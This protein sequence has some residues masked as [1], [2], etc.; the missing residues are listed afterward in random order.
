MTTRRASSSLTIALL[1]LLS[2]CGSEDNGMGANPALMGG[3]SGGGIGGTAAVTG[4]VGGTSVTTGG[5]GA[6]GAAGA[7]SG[8][9]GGVA[10]M[11]VTTTGG[12]DAMGGMG[13]SG[14]MD[15]T[16]GMSASGGMG[17]AAPVDGV[18]TLYWLNI[19]SNRVMRSVDFGPEEVIVTR[20]GTAPDGVAVD[21]AGGKVYWSNMGSLLGSGGGTMQRANLDGSDVE[22]II[23]AGIARTP[24]Q[25]Q[26]DLVNRH[27]YFCDRE[28]AK[29]WRAGMDGSNPEAI[30]TDKGYEELVGIALDVA[31]G[32]F[33]FG[34]RIGQK[35]MRANIE[36]P[37]G[38][39][40]ATRTDIEEMFVLSGSMPIDL[41]IDHTNKMIYWTDRQLGTVHRG[42]LEIPAGKTAE[43]RT[44]AE[45]LVTGLVE[46]IGLSLDVPNN[47]MYF[48]ELGGGIWES[49]LDGSGKKRLFSSGSATGI[50]IAHIPK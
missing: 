46:T 4:G 25:M 29:V 31:A 28:G 49:A 15:A 38:A 17:G 35:I 7:A 10:G 36:M 47:K 32:K 3:Q 16:G 2:G 5:M 34:D 45:T 37:A 39:T 33:Y 12:M 21:V 27:V 23:P 42:E 19:T 24:K 26:V 8:G 1:L 40:G 43:S 9:A 14:G 11:M 22:T 50:A 6:A 44:D 30:V 18:P 13:G 20:T 48:T 41:D